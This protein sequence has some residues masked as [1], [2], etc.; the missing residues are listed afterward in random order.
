[1]LNAAQERLDNLQYLANQVSPSQTEA[2]RNAALKQQIREVLSEREFRESL[3]PTVATAGYDRGFYIKSSDDLFYMKFNGWMQFRFTHY[4][5]QSR[6][7][8]LVIRGSSATTARDS[9]SSVFASAY[10]GTCTRRT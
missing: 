2:D 5:T 9:I 8:Y 7:R 1:M 10:A 6:N 3:M 4:G